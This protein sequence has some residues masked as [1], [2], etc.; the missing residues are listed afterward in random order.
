MP[1]TIRA[2]LEMMDVDKRRVPAARH[3]AAMLVP[4][5]HARD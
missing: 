5:A 1:A 3:L 2:R 4:T